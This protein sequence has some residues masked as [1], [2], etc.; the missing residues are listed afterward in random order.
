[1]IFLAYRTDFKVFVQFFIWTLSVSN[2]IVTFI[3]FANDLNQH[4][5]KIIIKLQAMIVI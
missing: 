4:S 3:L 2:L 1:M 5:D